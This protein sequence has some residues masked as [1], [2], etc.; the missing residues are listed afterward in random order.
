M[1][2]I[3]PEQERQRLIELYSHMAN[4]ELEA[5]AA[6]PAALTDAARKAL[7]GEITRRGLSIDL[8]DSPPAMENIELPEL[9]TIR[10][11]RDFN[12]ALL[13]KGLLESAAIE[14]FMTDENIAGLE[15]PIADIRLQVKSDD[16]EAALEILDQ[17]LPEDAEDEG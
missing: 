4:G 1:R 3:G 11:F 2:T 9:V 14:C 16:V 17:P 13:A 6:D 12:E 7:M 10:N 15:I 5:L 8:A